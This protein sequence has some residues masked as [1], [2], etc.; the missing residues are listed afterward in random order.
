MSQL[1]GDVGAQGILVPLAMHVLQAG[2][3]TS[4]L[5]DSDVL[6]RGTLWD[7][8]GVLGL[9]RSVWKPLVAPLY[10]QCGPWGGGTEVHMLTYLSSRLDLVGAQWAAWFQD[11]HAAAAGSVRVVPPQPPW[12][13]RAQGRPAERHCS[14]RAASAASAAGPF[15]HRGDRL[16][17]R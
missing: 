7:E 16:L 10:S 17:K 2:S 1:S 3:G 14:E 11:S 4:G 8:A 5:W 13:T 9:L 12:D 6:C 15:R